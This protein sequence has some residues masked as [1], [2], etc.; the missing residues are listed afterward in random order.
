MRRLDEALAASSRSVEA[1]PLSPFL[2]RLR[3]YLYYLMRQYGQAIEECNNA[4]EL[5]PGNL[6][7]HIH[8][9]QIYIGM[10]N[11]EEAIRILDAARKLEQY[12]TTTL[13]LLGFAYAQAGRAYEAEKI[14]EDL[15]GIAQRTY[16]PSESFARIL[17]GLG[18]VE[19]GFDW[20]E[21]AVE[22]RDSL[23]LSLNIAPLYDS[24]R[25]HPRYHALLRKMNLEA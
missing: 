17:F 16:V 9:G 24:L 6:P 11:A 3:G 5:D 23:I 13:D 19:K 18:E 2:R 14:F 10:G 20:L 4:L 1:N 8:L 25:S 15:Q 22:E 7:A 21:K 12:S